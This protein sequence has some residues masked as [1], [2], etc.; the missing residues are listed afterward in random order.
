MAKALE[1]HIITKEYSELEHI[2][3]HEN[4]TL[5]KR[6]SDGRLFVRKEFSAY[7]VRVLQCLMENP[8]EN[9]PRIESIAVNGN[10][11]TLIE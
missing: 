10:T 2:K 3:D 9:M 11:V 8:V 4:I 5:L 7:N 6:K 1:N